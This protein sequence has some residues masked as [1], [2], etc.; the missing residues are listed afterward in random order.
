MLVHAFEAALPPTPEA[1]FSLPS[2]HPHPPGTSN[3]AAPDG[4]T[5]TRGLFCCVGERR[6]NTNHR[7]EPAEHF[8]R[9]LRAWAPSAVW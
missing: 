1:H 9:P 7:T 4:R 6:G 5:R 2:L 8:G 3:C